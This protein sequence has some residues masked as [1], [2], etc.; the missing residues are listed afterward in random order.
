MVVR[1]PATALLIAAALLASSARAQPPVLVLRPEPSLAPL[2]R[3]V[4]RTLER[5]LGIEVSVGDPPPPGLHEA[6]PSGHVALAVSEARLSIVLAA[7]EGVA[8][9]T[10]LDL[11]RDTG[12]AAVRSVALAIEALL[13]ASTDAPSPGERPRG[14]ATDAGTWRTRWRIVGPRSAEIGGPRRA[15]VPLAK[16]T[17]HIRVLLGYSPTRGALLLGP[18]AGFG[19]CVTR[20]CVVLEGDLNLISDTRRASDDVL[21]RYRTVNFSVRVQLRPFDLGDVVPGLT[22][23]LATR[24]GS[25]SLEGTDVSRVVTNLAVRGTLELAWRFAPRFEAVLEAGM[26]LAINRAEFIRFGESL[27]LEDRWTPWFATSVRLRP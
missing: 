11:P 8:Y 15:I 4:V 27:L 5:R 26:D 24:V 12:D 20:H 2:A 10:E 14:A 3:R 23:G 6:V 13:D 9:A 21:V 22:F 25:A 7:D 17:I 18:G 16:P 1:G 19:L